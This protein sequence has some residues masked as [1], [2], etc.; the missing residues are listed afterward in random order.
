[1][2]VRPTPPRTFGPRAS[3]VWRRDDGSRPRD[4]ASTPTIVVE[5]IS[6]DG[7]RRM[8]RDASDSGPIQRAAAQKSTPFPIGAFRSPWFRLG[9]S[10]L[11]LLAFLVWP[12][13]STLGPA[14]DRRPVRRI[15]G[16]G[17]IAIQTFAFAPN[18]QTMATIQTDGRLALR[19]TGGDA[20]VPYFL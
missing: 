16:A 13:L 12:W 10:R 17:G 15:R 20:G 3:R 2:P 11:L 9:P 6:E 1:T 18:G 7:G 4:P 8:K 19:G 5:R 14:S